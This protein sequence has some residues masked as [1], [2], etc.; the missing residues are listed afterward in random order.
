MGSLFPSFQL[1]GGDARLSILPIPSQYFEKEKVKKHIPVEESE[2]VKQFVANP[3]K[4]CSKS[5]TRKLLPPSEVKKTIRRI[6]EIAELMKERDL[7]SNPDLWKEDD[8]RK[9]IEESYQKFR[10]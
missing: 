10:V 3:V 1:E 5:T 9:V 6:Q 2:V 7:P 4:R 8:V